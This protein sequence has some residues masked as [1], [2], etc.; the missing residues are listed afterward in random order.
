MYYPDISPQQAI[1]VGVT[2]NHAV[3]NR[4]DACVIAIEFLTIGNIVSKLDLV[5]EW[6]VCDVDKFNCVSDRKWQF[7]PLVSISRHRE[8]GRDP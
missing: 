6:V 3:Q 7:G 8:P 1:P 4:F 2:A 5:E